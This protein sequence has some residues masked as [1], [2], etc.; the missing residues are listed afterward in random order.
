LFSKIVAI[1]QDEKM[2]TVF[3]GSNLDDTR[4][5]RPGRKAISELQV[6]SPMCEAQLTKEEIRQLSRDAGLPTANKPSFACLA[7]RFPYGEHISKEK[8]SRVGKAEMELRALGF[9][10]FRVRSHGD[11]ARIEFIPA[12]MEQGW[13][14]RHRIDD[15][16]HKAGYTYVSIDIRGYRTGAM[17]E[18][19]SINK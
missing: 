1:A 6:R 13:K 3:D 2:D 5:Y 8:L 11:L 4:D 14:L 9:T 15:V 18:T 7:S 12:E 10:Q 16:F 19:L 17:N